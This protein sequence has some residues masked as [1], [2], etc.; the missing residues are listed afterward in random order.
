MGVVYGAA[1]LWQWK[2]TPDEEGWDAWASQPKSWKQALDMEGATY[3]GLVSKALAGLD[4]TDIEM[5]WDLV[6]RGNPPLLAHEGRL[7]I[8]FFSRGGDMGIRGVPDSLKFR[9]FD[10][11]TGR[12]TTPEPVGDRDHFTAPDRSPWVLIIE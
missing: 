10:P 5:R 4:L 3:V 12:T 6:D 7:Y 9:W 8:S 2:V 1:S 11:M